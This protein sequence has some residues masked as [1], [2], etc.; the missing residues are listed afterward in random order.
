[1]P[2]RVRDA[3]EN[4]L[5]V[6]YLEWLARPRLPE[7]AED[8][9]SATQLEAAGLFVPAQVAALREEARID[10]MNTGT[11]LMAVLTM[12]LWLGIFRCRMD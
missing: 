6:P 10:P 8:A 3:A 12:Q 7:W 5:R 4:P 11:L 1:V 2:E 9:L